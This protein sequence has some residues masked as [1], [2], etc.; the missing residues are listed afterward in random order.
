[1]NIEAIAKVAHEVNRAY[2][3]AMGDHSQLA[4]EEAPD[5]QRKS[6]VKGVEFHLA[7]PDATPV[8]S[9]ESW[10][11]EKEA[12]GWTWGKVKNEERK[13]H[14]CILPYLKLPVEQR[15]KDYIFSSI[16]RELRGTLSPEA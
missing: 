13:T 12:A 3:N 7:N 2:C 4:W 5:W 16:C 8:Q 1:M 10:R 11:E 9:H 6:A 15:A 14:P